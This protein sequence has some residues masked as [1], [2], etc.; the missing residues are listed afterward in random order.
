MNEKSLA[1][2]QAH[3]IQTVNLGDDFTK[4]AYDL[5]W[6]EIVEQN[7]KTGPALQKLLMK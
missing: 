6:K 7:P 1:S 4:R 3:G 5:Y 2:Q